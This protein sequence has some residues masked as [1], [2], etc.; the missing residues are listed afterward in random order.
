MSVRQIAIGDAEYDLSGYRG[1]D[2]R[3]LMDSHSSWMGVVVPEVEVEVSALSPPTPPGAVAP[4]GCMPGRP[5]NAS[6]FFAAGAEHPAALPTQPM[7]VP[8]APVSRPSPPGGVYQDYAG[9]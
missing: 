4:S 6:G 2:L 9:I 3:P 8:A 5:P 7:S 1:D